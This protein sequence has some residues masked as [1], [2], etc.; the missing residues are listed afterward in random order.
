LEECEGIGVVKG[1]GRLIRREK[2]MYAQ[3]KGLGRGGGEG[4]EKLDLV[5]QVSF[6]EA[7][8]D[9]VKKEI[10]TEK[11]TWREETWFDRS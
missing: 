9:D 4:G 3:R 11:P 2:T 8:A 5:G 10:R 7:V 6:G 1:R